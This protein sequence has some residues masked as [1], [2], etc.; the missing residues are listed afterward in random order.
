MPDVELPL[1]TIA[2]RVVGPATS[3]HAPVVFV[4]GALVDGRLWDQVAQL[5]G[6][7]GYRCYL[8]DWPLGSH[9]RPVRDRADLSVRGVVGAINDFLDALGLSDVTLVGNDSGGAICQFLVTSDDSRIGRLVLTN[10][11]TFGKFPPFPFSLEFAAFRGS[12]SI[13]LLMAPMRSTALR[14]S[15]LGYGLLATDPDPELT[16]SWLNPCLT[17]PEIRRDLARLIRTFRNDEL[18]AT[19]RAMTGFPKPVK[20][21]WGSADRAFKPEYARRLNALAP[22]SS[23]TEVPGA[24]TFLPLDRPQAVADGIVELAGAN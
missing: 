5:L 19:T 14:H 3:S 22:D 4:H 15:W 11:D 24:S 12:R 17:D 1:G 10:C 2:Y 7:A 23:L 16:R 18:D 9:T 8:P 20:L 13:A 21:V 6:D